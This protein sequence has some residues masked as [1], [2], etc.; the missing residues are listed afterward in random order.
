VTLI[1][2]ASIPVAGSGAPT[3]GA[4]ATGAE[5]AG[6]TGVEVPTMLTVTNAVTVSG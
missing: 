6:S 3:V 2:P 1:R 5:F 4:V